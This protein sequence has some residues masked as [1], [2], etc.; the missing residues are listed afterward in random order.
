MKNENH[1]YLGLDIGTD[2]VG[3]AVTDTSS[4]FRLIKHHGEPLWG[5]TLFEDAKLCSERRAFRVG[6]R[7]I[8]RRQ[9]RVA[10][11]QEIFAREIGKVD[12]NFYR[13]IK[14]SALFRED[15]SEPYCLFNDPDFSDADYHK[16]YPTIHHLICDLM[17]SDEP[18]DVRLVYIACAWLVAHRGHFLSEVAADNVTAMFAFPPIYN[19]FID[20][21]RECTES[22]V[23]VEPWPQS[24]DTKKEFANILKLRGVNNKKKAFAK[25]LFNGKKIPKTVQT[26]E[27]VFPF[28]VE[29]ILTL[30]AGGKAALSDL[31]GNPEY[32]DLGSFSLDAKEEDYQAMLAQLGDDAELIRKL[33]AL[34][35]W[36]VL[37]DLCGGKR[38]ISEAKVD[39]YEQHRRDL[40]WLKTFVRENY[41]PEVYR[42]VFRGVCDN[43]Y[44]AY[45]GNT[46]SLR[47]DDAKYKK[48]GNRADFC[49]FLK[50]TLSLEK[51]PYAS[52]I[53][54]DML[55]RITDGDFMPKQVTGDNRVLPYQLYYAELSQILQKAAVYLPFLRETD[56]GGCRTDEKLLSIMRYRIP[57]YVGPLNQSGEH[58]W[59]VR[60]AEGRI[61]PWNF[62]KMVDHDASEEAFIDRMT[63]T[64]TY[65]AGEEV[66]P[67]NALLYQKFVV[68]NE[69]NSIKICSAPIDAALKQK[70]YT[71]LFQRKKKVTHRALVAFLCECGIAKKDAETVSGI[72][73]NIKGSLSSRIAFRNLLEKKAL[74]DTDVEQIIRRRTY[75]EDKTRFGKWL[76]AAYPALSEEDRHY[77]TTL[78][79]KDFGRLSEKLLSGIEGANTETGEVNTVIGFMWE[80]NVTLSELL[81]SDRYTFAGRIREENAAYYGSC[82]KSLNERLDDMYVSNAVKRPI[83][84]TLE[85]VSDVVKATGRAPD[86]IYVEM[87]RGANE[88]QKGKRAKTRKEILLDR[89]DQTKSEE[90]PQL[91][92]ILESYGADAD[93]KL[94]SD[95]LYLYFM[96]LGKCMYT[97]EPIS[98]EEIS[99]KRYDIDHIYPQSRVDDDSI[100]NNKVL[101]VSEENHNKGNKYPIDSGIR[102]RMTG[103]WK[104]LLDNG[105][106]TEEKFR[107]LTR[108]TSFTEEEEWNFVNRQLV[109]TRQ[110]TKVITT[111]LAEKYPDTEIVFVKAKL[112]SKFRHE[113]GLLKSR[114][115]NDLH[116][117]KDAYLNI[118]CGEVYHSVFTKQWFLLNRGTKEYTINM[119]ALLGRTQT[120][121][122]K[123]IWSGNASLAAVKQTMRKNH[124]HLTM[125]PFCRRG[126]L[127]DQQPKRKAEGLVPRKAGLPTEKYGGYQKPTATFFSLALCTFGKK[128][129]ILIL[130]VDL[131]V[132]DRFRNDRDF[133]RQYLLSVAQ[134]LLGD[135]KKID[136]IS[137]PLGERILKIYTVFEADGFRMCLGGKSGKQIS[138]KPLMPLI[139]S[140][141]WETYIKKLESFQEKQKKNAKIL[142]DAEHEIITPEQ[143]RMLY[144]ILTEKLSQKPFSLRPTLVLDKIVGREAEFSALSFDKQVTVLLNLVTLF[145]R[146]AS[147]KDDFLQLSGACVMSLCLSNWK[148]RYGS[149]YLIDASASGIWER[150]SRNLLAL[151]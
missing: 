40:A 97:G 81:L 135:E 43:N 65:L 45:S 121:G 51:E 89:Y 72:D 41:T 27:G 134:D 94:Q 15:S 58:S 5:V 139:L 124:C 18:H 35:D 83:I 38:Y 143:N 33:K 105:L 20:H 93:N 146:S 61:Y 91:R 86:K 21:C 145:G 17:E 87:A 107:R 60:R 22:D 1:Y 49:A 6:R 73:T 100:L 138:I 29:A 68:L 23:F 19:D 123:E 66:L 141:E 80:K 3:Y 96:Q 77:I 53:S 64:C 110:S 69:I 37:S 28:S 137:F 85:I 144:T 98:L 116:H 13:R 125:Y 133:A 102:E 59:I 56:E 67:Q 126:G 95:R 99:A 128:R 24:E 79:M 120:V 115:I 111:L 42:T 14:E 55:K 127:F 34:Y 57:Y 147:K 71:E 9:Q 108:A 150:R 118:V 70:I 109:E 39:V 151:L 11:V 7:R 10:L 82:K 104:K 119:H 46:S 92:K 62:D 114:T 8:D 50:K 75:C 148:K 26:E 140:P 142:Y 63:N 78:V 12:E 36:A 112:A 16:K 136:G 149:L 74:T 122:T 2:S 106:I 52:A 101:V 113:Y 25:F 117:A 129:D 31:Y 54:E 44:V 48:C 88:E 84:R 130:P 4:D 90:V 47:E 76:D 30:L 103:F 32:E 131:M 132:A